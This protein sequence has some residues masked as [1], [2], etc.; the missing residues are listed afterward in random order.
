VRAGASVQE[1]GQVVAAASPA[2]AAVVAIAVLVK[3]TRVLM[4]ALVVA[5]VSVMKRVKSTDANVGARR[6]PLVPLFV[7]GFVACAALRSAHLVPHAALGH[8][9]TLQTAALGAALFGMGASV[10]LGSLLRKSGQVVLVAAVS[11]VF[12]ALVSLG[13]ILLLAKG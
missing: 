10:H 11:S 5:T 12:I 9:A 2:G 1:V 13:G 6:P 4:L 3:L 7:L 8:L